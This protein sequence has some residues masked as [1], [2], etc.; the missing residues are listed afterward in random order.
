MNIY[1]GNI[2]DSMGSLNKFHLYDSM[3]IRLN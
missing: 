2:D 1:V 3:I